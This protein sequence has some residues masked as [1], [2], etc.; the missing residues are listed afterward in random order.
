M[1]RSSD[2]DGGDIHI[3]IKASG[4]SGQL[5]R[6]PEPSNTM[7]AEPNNLSGD[8]DF[9]AFDQANGD[10]TSWFGVCHCSYTFEALD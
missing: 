10:P 4:D 2:R 5:R 9:N 6:K 8:F 1:R 3:S 7:S